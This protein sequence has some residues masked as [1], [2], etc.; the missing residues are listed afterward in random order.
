MLFIVTI[1]RFYIA[2]ATSKDATKTRINNKERTP[3]ILSEEESGKTARYEQ[4]YL[5]I[6]N[7]LS[8]VKMSYILD[9]NKG[10]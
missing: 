1:D 2:F 10:G 4:E 6:E 7:G 5:A 8:D 9:I 3:D